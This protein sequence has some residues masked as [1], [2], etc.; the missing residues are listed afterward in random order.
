MTKME[1]KGACCKTFRVFHTIIRMLP[2]WNVKDIITL[3]SWCACSIR[4]LPEWN[5]KMY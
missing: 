4:M 3:D 1:C 2:E 5:V